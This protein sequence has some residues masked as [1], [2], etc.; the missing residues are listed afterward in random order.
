LKDEALKK[1]PGSK[2]DGRLLLFVRSLFVLERALNGQQMERL[3]LLAKVKE[4]ERERERI[5]A[6]YWLV[7]KEWRASSP[8]HGCQDK[9]WK[10]QFLFPM[11]LS[12]PYIFVLPFSFSDRS[13]FSLGG[14]W[15]GKRR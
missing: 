7:R 3:L 11:N 14:E 1:H 5:Q 13:T 6:S 12:I 2:D 4:R 15:E 9:P 8:V 10:D